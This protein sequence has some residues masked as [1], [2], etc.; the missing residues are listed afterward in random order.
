M[1]RVLGFVKRLSTVS[2][3]LLPGA[4]LAVMATIKQFMHVSVPLPND[5]RARLVPSPLLK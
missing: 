5:L 1:Q 3:Q 4:C 2:L